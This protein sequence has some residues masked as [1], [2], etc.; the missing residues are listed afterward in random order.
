MQVY[1]NDENNYIKNVSSCNDIN[2]VSVKR[3]LIRTENVTANKIRKIKH[4]G[5][6]V[7]Y[8][9]KYGITKEE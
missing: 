5:F 8:F 9:L 2:A 6:L 7:N 1:E 3:Y 4:D